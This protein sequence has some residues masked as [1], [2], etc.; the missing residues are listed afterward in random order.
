M[1]LTKNH[2]IIIAVVAVGLLAVIGYFIYRKMKK[3]GFDSTNPLTSS[4]ENPNY[5]DIGL[6][7]G[8][9]SDSYATLGSNQGGSVNSLAASGYM[10]PM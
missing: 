5:N 1:E 6:M 7:S 2:K 8:G 10:E 9:G 4:V 3:E